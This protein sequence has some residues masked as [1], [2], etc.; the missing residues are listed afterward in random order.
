MPTFEIPSKHVPCGKKGSALD[1]QASDIKFYPTLE[2]KKRGNSP[3]ST[4]ANA[5]EILCRWHYHNF[6]P[7]LTH[8]FTTFPLKNINTGFSLSHIFP[9]FKIISKHGPWDKTG[10][11]LD[12][13]TT[14]SE[15]YSTLEWKKGGD[16]PVST[17]THASEMLRKWHY[18]ISFKLFNPNSV[19]VFLVHNTVYAFYM[20]II[21]VI[22]CI[23]YVQIFCTFYFTYIILLFI[24]TILIYVM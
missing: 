11:A 16:S 24:K 18:H 20:H 2:G 19:S 17:N 21:C 3:V 8:K 9:T 23:K 12:S 7:L 10:K 4:N 5:S 14:D 6:L 22:G 13:R 1:S 15:F